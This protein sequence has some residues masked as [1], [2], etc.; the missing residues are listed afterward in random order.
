MHAGSSAVAP[1]FPSE[2]LSNLWQ[3]TSSAGDH[4]VLSVSLAAHGGGVKQTQ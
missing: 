3:N 4:Y 1:L 2:V